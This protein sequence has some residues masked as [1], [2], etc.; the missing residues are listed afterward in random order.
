ML[1]MATDK[2]MFLFKPIFF[3]KKGAPPARFFLSSAGQVCRMPL[4]G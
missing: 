4:F 3:V 1:S 2:E